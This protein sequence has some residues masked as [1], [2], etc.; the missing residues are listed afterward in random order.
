MKRM[1]IVRHAKSDHGPRYNTDF[2]RP[3]NK[4]GNRDAPLMAK[5]MKKTTDKLDKILVSAAKRTRETATYFINE[6]N[7]NKDQ[8]DFE[9]VLYLPE[10]EE[11]WDVVRH[12]ND[13]IDTVAVFT[14]NPAVENLLHR[15][16]PGTSAPTCSVIEFHYDGENWYGI[17]PE[18]IRFIS[19]TYPKLYV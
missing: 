6:Y 13:D 15:Y 7:L 8:V 2:E 17:D 9:E 4:R 11:I 19:H 16:R 18:K 14:H 10:E 1:W 5:E 3:L 12:I